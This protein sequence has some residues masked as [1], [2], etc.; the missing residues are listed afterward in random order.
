MTE[1]RNG[2]A[3]LVMF[4]LSSM[5]NEVAQDSEIYCSYFLLPSAGGY[6]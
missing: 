5:N 2:I 4:L 1:E 3:V 6:V